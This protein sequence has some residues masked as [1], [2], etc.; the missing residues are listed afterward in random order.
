MATLLDVPRRILDYRFRR[1][2]VDVYSYLGILIGN[3]QITKTLKVVRLMKI[4]MPFSA[5][6]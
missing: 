1:V 3:G 5:R 6:V 4:V 2:E